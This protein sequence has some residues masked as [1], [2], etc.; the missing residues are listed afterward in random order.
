[1][2]KF[3]SIFMGAVCAMSLSSTAQAEDLMKLYKY[4]HANPELSL[5]ETETALL[6]SDKLDRPW[7]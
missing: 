5:M 1:M 2:R 6:L 4:L 3:A 7:L